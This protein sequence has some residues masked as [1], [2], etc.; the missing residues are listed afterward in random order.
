MTRVRTHHSEDAEATEAIARSLAADLK[1]GDVVALHG[2]LGAG[3]TR[4]V[5]GLAAGLGH[6]ERLVSSPTFVIVNEYAHAG[7]RCPV[8]H[9]DAYRLAGPD[10]ADSFDL[11][12]LLRSGAVVAVEW[13]ER[14]GDRMPA[15]AVRVT[16]EHAGESAR[17]IVIEMASVGPAC[18]ACGSPIAPGAATFPFCSPR[19]RIADLG[20]WFN[21]EYRVTRDLKDT[22]L[23]AG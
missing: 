1:P 12:G 21:A 11:E 16:I 19:C 3:K 4:F 17:R 6:L 7:A 13:P 23:E 22:D 20:K 8:V 2:D 14:L 15:P 5:R 18:R 10:D 9:I